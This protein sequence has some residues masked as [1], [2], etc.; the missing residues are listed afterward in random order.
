MVKEMDSGLIYISRDLNYKFLGRNGDACRGR[1]VI[2][3]QNHQAKDDQGKKEEDPLLAER[4]RPER[5]QAADG[6]LQI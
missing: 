5:L 4:V 6:G 1:R 2:E 3:P